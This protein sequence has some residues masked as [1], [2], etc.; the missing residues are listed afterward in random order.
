MSHMVAVDPK[1]GTR[2]V[3]WLGS[4]S[5]CLRLVSFVW[6]YPTGSVHGPVDSV[7]DPAGTTVLPVMGT[8]GSWAVA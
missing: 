8:N 6:V 1:P 2:I 7:G 5:I 4:D 3:D